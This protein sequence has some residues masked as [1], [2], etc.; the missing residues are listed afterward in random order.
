MSTIM[1]IRMR[2][3]MLD[4]HDDQSGCNNHLGDENDDGDDGRHSG[5]NDEFENDEYDDEDDDEGVMA[6]AIAITTVMIAIISDITVAIIINIL[7]RWCLW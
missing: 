3:K 6:T 7:V 1:V 2:I 5:H 4:G